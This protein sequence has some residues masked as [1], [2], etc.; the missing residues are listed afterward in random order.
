MGL[1]W[2]AARQFRD[3]V[4]TVEWRASK[5]GDNSG[6]FVRFPDPRGDPWDAVDRG[7]EVQILDDAPEADRRTG[8]I[9][10]F[11]GPDVLLSRPAGQWNRLEVRVE[12]Q[13]Y[14]VTVNDQE[15]T[16]FRG[17]RSDV[18]HI[19]LQNH[20]DDSRVQFRLVRVRELT[21]P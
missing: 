5:P 19:G 3:F 6:V 13:D 11:A 21:S 9:Y 14:L 7:Y 12:G 20:D 15:A 1:L 8:A 18:G 2:Y 17:D 16:R 10:R 4:L